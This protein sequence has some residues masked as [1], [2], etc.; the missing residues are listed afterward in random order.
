MLYYRLGSPG[1]ERRSD[2]N[3]GDLLRRS[4]VGAYRRH[5]AAADAVR[6]P[7]ARSNNIYICELI[8]AV[9]S[10]SRR[11]SPSLLIDRRC[12]PSRV[13]T[14]S[15]PAVGLRW[16][17]LGIP[18]SWPD[19]PLEPT[20]NWPDA[21]PRV[22]HISCGSVDC[23]QLQ[24]GSDS[25][26]KALPWWRALNPDFRLVLHD[27]AA[28]LRFVRSQF[29]ERVATRYEALPRWAHRVK[30][31][32]WRVLYLL[33]HG[34]VYADAD[35]EPVASLRSIV[36][37]GDTFV[38]SASAHAGGFVNPHFIIA[39]PAEPILNETARHMLSA[40]QRFVR[41]QPCM[42]FACSLH[43]VLGRALSMCLSASQC[44]RP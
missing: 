39:R 44:A 27:D 38:T 28:C 20:T 29:G 7:S 43:A 5:P 16:A 10:M 2:D 37:P 30:S 26:A 8:A 4:Q 23:A 15:C 21:V 31:D 22:L 32:L 42:P 14:L 17:G 19:A 11:T 25:P 18:A 12:P 41:T 9:A 40:M 34:G 3:A 36:E 1:A 24:A 33:K 35:I 13:D 6:L